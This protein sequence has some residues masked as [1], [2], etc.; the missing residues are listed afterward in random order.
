MRI[1]WV[2]SNL[3]DYTIQTRRQKISDQMAADMQRLETREQAKIEFKSL[4][5]AARGGCSKFDVL[6]RLKPE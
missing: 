1:N 4:S 3:I 5:G 2:N 6:M